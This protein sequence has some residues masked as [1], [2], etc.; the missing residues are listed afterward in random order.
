LQR[1]LDA[2][3]SRENL[4]AIE[5]ACTRFFE[6]ARVLD[7]S[8]VR[9]DAGIYLIRELASDMLGLWSPEKP[10]AGDRDD[11]LVTGPW[12]DTDSSPT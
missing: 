12:H 4:A 3:F 7:P 6:K 5:E 9:S 11:A 8:S 1:L 2:R 10:M